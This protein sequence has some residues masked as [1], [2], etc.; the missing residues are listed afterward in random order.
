MLVDATTT[1][2]LEYNKSS[3]TASSGG[4]LLDRLPRENTGIGASFD[5]EKNSKIDED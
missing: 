2:I 5:A 4:E 1:P 3:L